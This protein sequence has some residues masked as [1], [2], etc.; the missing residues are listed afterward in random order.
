[1]QQLWKQLYNQLPDPNLP[2]RHPSGQRLTIRMAVVIE[3]VEFGHAYDDYFCRVT[4]RLTASWPVVDARIAESSAVLGEEVLLDASRV[5]HPEVSVPGARRLEHL[6]RRLELQSLLDLHRP[7]PKTTR[8]QNQIQMQQQQQLPTDMTG[9]YASDDPLADDGTSPVKKTPPGRRREMQ[10]PLFSLSESINVEVLCSSPNVKNY[11]GSIHCPIFLKHETFARERPEF[12]WQDRTGCSVTEQANAKLSY[13]TVSS[14]YSPAAPGVSLEGE[15]AYTGRSLKV[16][17]ELLPLRHSWRLPLP[18]GGG[19]GG[20]G[21]GGGGGGS[22][23]GGDDGGGG[24]SGRGCGGGGGGGDTQPSLTVNLCFNPTGQVLRA[25]VPGFIFVC[26]SFLLLWSLSCGLQVVSLAQ[27]L[28]V[29]LA[30]VAWSCSTNGLLSKAARFSLIDAWFL[31]CFIFISATFL[32]TLV[33]HRRLERI[34]KKRQMQ[35]QRR[36]YAALSASVVAA[37]AATKLPPSL[38]GG[39]SGGSNCGCGGGCCGCAGYCPASANGYMLQGPGQTNP[40]GNS[41]PAPPLSLL[42]QA[43]PPGALPTKLDL[44]GEA[45]LR[46]ASC[47][48]AKDSSAIMSMGTALRLRCAKNGGLGVFETNDSNLGLMK[49]QYAATSSPATSGLLQ[50]LSPVPPSYCTTMFAAV[51]PIL[52]LLTTIIFWGSLGA[53]G[54]VPKECLTGSVLCQSLTEG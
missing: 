1:M 36:I 19:V 40:L 8:S 43:S 34:L 37:A 2:N 48:L 27:G 45:Y 10:A 49:S 22:G 12:A 28:L 52:F 13:A 16:M 14:K 46:S 30:L 50:P 3:S 42:H 5:W 38:G 9:D 41:S 53:Q 11:L 29:L 54:T 7:T 21:G 47:E 6:S 4:L 25:A 35:Q 20:G 18:G 15:A 23:G 26:L 31:V 32:F 39:G 51:V 17:P 33:E 24:G 44:C